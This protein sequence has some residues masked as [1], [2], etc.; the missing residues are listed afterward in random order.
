[1]KQTTITIL[2]SGASL[3]VY[4]PGLVTNKQLRNKGL[5]TEIVV[6]ENLLFEE[7][8]NNEKRKKTKKKIS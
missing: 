1:M 2:C 5:N 6:L 3:G 4:V 7:K 8:K